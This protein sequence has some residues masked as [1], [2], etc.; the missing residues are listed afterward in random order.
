M[1]RIYLLLVCLVLSA[2]QTPKSHYEQLTPVPFESLRGW[3]EDQIAAALPALRK[4]CQVILAKNPSTDMLTRGDGR[5]RARDWHPFCKTIMA[6]NDASGPAL[7]RMIEKHL[8][9]YFVSDDGDATGTFTGYYEPVLKGSRKR[10]GPYQTPLY[11][12]PS[13]RVKHKV[14]RSRIVAGALKGKGLEI[15]W[16]DDPVDAFFL[17]IQGSGKVVLE[18]GKTIRLGFG[19]QN[20]YPYFP[21]GKALVD[22]GYLQKGEV[23]MQSIKRW[24]R[25]NPAKAESIMSLNQSYVFFKEVADGPIGSQG[26]SLTP[27]RSLAVD[28]TYISLGTPLWVDID[29]IPGQTGKLRRLMVAQDTGGAIQ[30]VVRGDVFWGSGSDAAELAGRMNAQGSYYVLLPR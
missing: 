4:S 25:S 22:K 16:V 26:V 13:G 18:N 17:Q 30:G 19:G 1:N 9:P 2:C 20:G 24:L 7:R 15:V 3:Q 29:R 27:G 28:R 8:Q 5:G 11:R 12:H 23:S 6:T 14:P 10:H 21:I